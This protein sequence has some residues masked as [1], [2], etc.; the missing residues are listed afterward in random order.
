MELKADSALVSEALAPVFCKQLQKLSF[1]QPE[2]VM[3]ITTAEMATANLFIFIN[4][5][6]IICICV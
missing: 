4:S 5:P 3:E 1:S 6:F 2:K